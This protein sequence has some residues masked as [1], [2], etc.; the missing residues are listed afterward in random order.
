MGL[1]K[2]NGLAWVSVVWDSQ[3]PVKSSFDSFVSEMREVFAHPVYGR[4]AAK[5]LLSL[6]QGSRQTLGGMTGHFRV[7]FVM[8]L[9]IQL[10]MIS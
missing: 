5:R 6:R 3:S 10:R 4:D 1:L 7:F 8:G 9:I 2:G